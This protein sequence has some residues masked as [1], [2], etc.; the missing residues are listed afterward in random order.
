MLYNHAKMCF[1]VVNICIN[2]TY[3]PKSYDKFIQLIK[4]N[5][6]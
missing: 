4:K 2:I 1:F 5:D 6:T 3:D